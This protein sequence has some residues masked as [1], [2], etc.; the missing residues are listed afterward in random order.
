VIRDLDTKFGMRRTLGHAKVYES[1]ED[2]RDIEHDHMLDRNKIDGDA[3]RA[4]SEAGS[5]AEEA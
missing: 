4:G 5:E 3:E 1:P 2:A